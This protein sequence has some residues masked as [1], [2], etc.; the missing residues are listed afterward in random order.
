M[1]KKLAV[2]LCLV[3]TAL[4]T[5]EGYSSVRESLSSFASN[6]ELLTPPNF[7]SS[8]IPSLK[9]KNES[10]ATSLLSS[11]STTAADAQLQSKIA[12]WFQEQNSAKN[13][14]LLLP[15]QMQPIEIT[16]TSA[17]QWA[18][19]DID[20]LRDIF[21]TNRNTFW[22][23][24]DVETGRQLYHTLLPR[25]LIRLHAQG[26]EPLELA[27]LAYKARVAAK[28]YVR[29]RSRVPGRVTAVA[30]DG[31]RHLKNYG[32]W[33]SMGMTWD[34]LWNKYERQILEEDLSAK[35]ASDMCTLDDDDVTSQVCLRIL[36]RSCHTNRA[37]D[38]LVLGANSKETGKSRNEIGQEVLAIAIELDNEI[39]NLLNKQDEML[40]KRRDVG[41][42]I[43]SLGTIV[44]REASV[45]RD[46]L[47]RSG[48]KALEA[49]L[50]TK[51]RLR[52]TD[53]L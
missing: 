18:A 19:T 3:A 20:T 16:A 30:I 22:G 33:R 7:L 11:S 39:N 17:S 41:S 1:E 10:A 45:L 42:K 6:T 35:C 23:D 53:V 31:F 8:D 36:E 29:E 44:E 27:P 48:I 24:L 46:K 40:E 49:L 47:S 38:E 25:A 50:S 4:H 2:A 26:V 32:N 15:T 34:E 37:I 43:A 13:E 51:A 9:Y 14:S 21:G 5:A 52:S 28:E 12:K